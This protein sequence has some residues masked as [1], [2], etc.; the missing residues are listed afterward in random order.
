MVAW[1]EVSVMISER[2]LEIIKTSANRLNKPVRLVLFT[3]DKGCPACPGMTEL[4]R[5]IKAHFDKI[6]LE[7][8]DMVMD[9]DKSHQ[10]GI[11]RVPAIVLQGGD[12][13]AVTFYGSVEGGLLKIFMDTIRSFSDTKQW[14]PEDVRRVLKKLEHDVTIRVFVDRDC[15]KCWLAAETAIALALESRLIVADIIVADD[16]PE[17]VKKHIVK[18]LPTTIF[19]EN[20]RMEG[21]VSESRFLEMIFE[22][23]GIKPGPDQ[24]CLVCG[25]PS[26]D[27]ICA[28]CKTRIHAEAIDHK[29]RKEKGLQQP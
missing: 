25:K 7:S 12:G 9:L 28:N 14:F 5:A 21:P 2:S 16:F 11:E 22:A 19:G 23:E 18:E 17:L 26:Q 4:A 13:E 15:P 20:L 3:S 24:R 27:V 6:A 1:G 8:Y 10:Y 29:T